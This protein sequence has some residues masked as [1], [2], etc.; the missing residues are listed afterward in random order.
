MTLLVNSLTSPNAAPIIVQQP[1]YIVSPGAP[2]QMLYY[3]TD[4]RSQWA[5]PVGLAATPVLPLALTITPKR[6]NSLIIMQWMINGE[7]HWSTVWQIYLFN[8]LI[9]TPGY[10][11]TNNAPVNPGQWVGYVS[12]IYDAA[13][14]VSSTMENTFI[15]YSIVLNT[16]DTLTFYPAIKSSTTAAYT[17]N[18]NRTA[19]AVGQ[20]SYENTISTGTIMEIPQ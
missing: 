9:T 8:S 19:G 7:A 13:G 20:D 16:T 11:G 4:E 10:Q 6:P 18:L 5:A 3:R 1:S 12:G 17:F 15:Q 2:I 14:D